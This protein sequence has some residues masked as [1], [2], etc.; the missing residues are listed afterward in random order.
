MRKGEWVRFVIR[1]EVLD[2]DRFR[3]MAAA[4]VAVSRD[5]PGTVVYDWYLD[6]AEA[7]GTLYEAYASAE[8]LRAHGSGAVFT[9]L[10]PRYADTVRVAKVD[11]FGA[12]DGLPRREV[13]GAPT[14]WWGAPVAAV[15]EAG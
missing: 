14:T 3:E 6:E 11:A 1:F 10:A 12:V 4:M 8:A 2:A 9:E 13:L 7:T 15:T 5:E